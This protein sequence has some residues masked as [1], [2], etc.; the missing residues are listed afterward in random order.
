MQQYDKLVPWAAGGALVLS[1]T[2]LHDVASAVDS[3]STRVVLAFAWLFLFLSLA[4]SIVG[5]FTSSRVYS[6]SRAAL[7]L[8][9]RG[10]GSD[11]TK[12]EAAK[13]DRIAKLSSRATYWL[14]YVSGAGLVVGLA[15]LGVFA[16]LILW[17]GE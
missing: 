7:D 13:Q 16:F 5:H 6:S 14:N 1:I 9:H 2:L 3:T 4:G 12:R 15:L 11:E 8:A 17:K 10:E